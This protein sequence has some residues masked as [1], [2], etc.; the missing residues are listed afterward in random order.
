MYVKL[1]IILLFCLC[2]FKVRVCEITKAQ[3]VI[4]KDENSHLLKALFC[5]SVSSAVV[6]C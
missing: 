5:F 6:F 4:S 2:T 3:V 1:S